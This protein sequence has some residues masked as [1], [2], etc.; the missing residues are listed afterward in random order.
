MTHG[1]M[2]WGAALYNNGSFPLKQARFGESYSMNGAP[3]RL[4]TV[5]PPTRLG[6]QGQGRRA[7][8]RSA[9]PLRGEP[10]GQHPAHLRARRAAPRRDRHPRT[11]SRKPG[12]PARR[13]SNRG[14]GTENRTDPVLRQP[15]QDA[16]LRP[17]AQLPR[18]PTTTPATIAPAAAP[19]ATSSTPTTAR[20]ST[21]ARTPRSATWGSSFNPDPTIPKNEPGHPIEHRF[22]AGHPDQPVHR[23]P[24]PPRHQR[25]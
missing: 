17:D 6:D 12:R 18:A 10:A 14:L 24:H 19:P 9:A 21:P 22:T 13:L 5:P 2:L 4:Q 25:A 1:S 7:V 11:R 16:A 8:P 3:Q 20:R 15:A 23:L